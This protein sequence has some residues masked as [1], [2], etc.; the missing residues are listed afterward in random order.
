MA[1]LTCYSCFAWWAA[2]LTDMLSGC[3]E[4][5]AGSCAHKSESAVEFK[6]K[7]C[8]VEKTIGFSKS[9]SQGGDNKLIPLDLSK[10]T[11]SNNDDSSASST[12]TAGK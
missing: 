12:A 5:L 4:S 7:Q 2:L 8:K 6:G 3:L 11:M 9:T 1:S 10:L